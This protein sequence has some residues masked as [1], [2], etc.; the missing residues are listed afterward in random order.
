MLL[1]VEKEK[2]D[3]ERESVRLFIKK[4]RFAL[5][6]VIMLFLK[7]NLLAQKANVWYFGNQIG[8]D[9]NFNPAT[10]LTN[11]KITIDSSA[12]STDLEPSSTISDESGNL[13]FY[14]NGI[15][16]WNRL[17]HVMPNGKNLFGNTTTTQ[18]LI[19]Q[20]PGSKTNYFI[21]TCSP[22]GNADFFPVSQKGFWY[23]LVDISL[24]GGRGDVVEKN[25]LLVPSTTEKIAATYHAN[26]SDI[27]V[28]MH[29]WN[30]NVFNAFLINETGIT[31]QVRSE[32]GNWHES[33]KI[34]NREFNAIGQMKFSPNGEKLALAVYN[35]HLAEIFDFDPSTGK[36]TLDESI[37]QFDGN[38]YGIEFSP[39][40]K[41]LY[42]TDGG[43]Y[44][45]QYDLESYPIKDSQIIL[46]NVPEFWDNPSQLQLAPDG[47]IYVAKRDNYFLGIINKPNERGENCEYVNRGM[48]LPVGKNFCGAGLPNF[49][50]S[51]FYDPELYPP[52]PYFEMPNVFTPNE[53]GFNDRFGPI[54][55]FNIKSWQLVVFNRWGQAVY[56][57]SDPNGSWEGIDF[58]PGIYYWQAHYEGVNGKEFI[59]KGTVQLIR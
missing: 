55:K 25:I 24:D 45:Y 27:W 2:T 26:G 35:N 58:S 22:Q 48:M 13:L 41:L 20:K 56:Q 59:E 17:H 52:R 16:V 44:V 18:T 39:S 34:G 54:K 7:I 33:D 30:N 8:I 4:M 50:S 12:I 42:V 6:I 11:G 37:K 57:T 31:K 53:D 47:K 15:Q 19:V 49:L 23:S 32:S 46:E 38:V 29:E 40:G 1:K 28:I 51:Y 3:I 14:T 21:F 5:L 9:F 43:R 36:I 10:I